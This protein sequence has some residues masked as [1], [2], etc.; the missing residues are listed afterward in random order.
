MLLLDLTSD[1][2]NDRTETAL[3][4]LRQRLG[5]RAMLAGHS[6]EGLS[7]ASPVISGLASGHGRSYTSAGDLLTYAAAAL[8][9][10]G[11]T[12]LAFHPQRDFP[13]ADPFMSAGEL[14]F[15]TM[16]A[17]MLKIDQIDTDPV[18]L[19]F[20]VT[21][22]RTLAQ[23]NY[24]IDMVYR[25]GYRETRFVDLKANDSQWIIFTYTPALLNGSSIGALPLGGI[26]ISELNPA[27][28]QKINREAMEGMGMAPYYVAYLA[29]EKY[30]KEGNYSE[31][32]AEYNRAVSLSPDYAEAYISRGNAQRRNGNYD[33]AIEDYSRALRLN[34]SYADV[35]NY[36]GF[37]Y[38]QKGDYI[39][40]IA[41]YTQAIRVRADYTDA[42]F[43]RAYAY[44]KQGNWDGAIAD[45]TQVINLEPSNSVAYNERGHAWKGKGENER[46][47]AD[48]GAA[49]RLKSLQ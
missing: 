45:Y 4:R 42:F 3:K 15:Q 26:N 5:P 8:S 28:Y 25:N 24:I 49:E 41:D 40:A 43:N 13:L 2:S 31:A 29:G 48:Y 44:G 22:T 7:I 39:R 1:D 30:Y 16:T 46:A 18:S 34:N 32:I 38:T 6:A 47:E 37:A 33:R 11:K 14:K 10:Q 19:V 27:N 36:R 12:F 9:E 23:G 35:Y 21:I 20:G 17:G